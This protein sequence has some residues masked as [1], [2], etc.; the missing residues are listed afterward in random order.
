VLHNPRF[1][2]RFSKLQRRKLERKLTSG[3]KSFIDALLHLQ[4]ISI[5]LLSSALSHNRTGERF[6][7]AVA[8]AGL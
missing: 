1:C 3:L 7:D 6:A 8:Q 5:K 4:K 2:N